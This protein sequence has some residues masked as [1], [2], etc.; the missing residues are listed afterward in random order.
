MQ[1]VFEIAYLKVSDLDPAIWT[2]SDWGKLALYNWYFLRY[3]GLLFY[4][5]KHYWTI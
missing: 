1:R 2:M 3:I 4:T 5:N